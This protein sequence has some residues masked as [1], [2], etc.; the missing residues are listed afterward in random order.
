MNFYN[1][2][3][4]QGKAKSRSLFISTLARRDESG[5]QFV[6]INQEVPVCP[7]L[8][9][10]VFGFSTRTLLN[11][12]FN[13]NLATYSSR[14]WYSKTIESLS[15][16]LFTLSKA[17]QFNSLS[18]L[19]LPPKF[20]SRSL[21]GESLGVSVSELR[22]K[23]NVNIRE[24][25]PD[26]LTRCVACSTLPEMISK[27]KTTPEKKEADR[28]LKLH[29]LAI[30]QQRTIISCLTKQSRDSDSDVSVCMFDAMAN[31]HTKL[32][33]IN[34]R[35]KNIPDADLIPLNLSTVQL[36]ECHGISK[37]SSL[38]STLYVVLDSSRNNKS[39]VFLGALGLTL[40]QLAHLRKIVLLYPSVGHTHLSVDAHFGNVSK[41]MAKENIKDP[42]EFVSFLKT[43]PSVIDVEKLPTIFDFDF[44]TEHM[45]KPVGLCSNNVISI[46]KD[47]K[48]VIYYSSCLTLNASQLVGAETNEV[49]R[50]LFKDSFYESR[51]SP[52]IKK[53]DFSELRMKIRNLLD[54]SRF[55]FSSD[56][57]KNFLEFTSSF[58]KTSFLQLISEINSIPTKLPDLEI[59]ETEDIQ[60]TV[61]AFLEKHKVN[62]GRVPKPPVVSRSQL[63]P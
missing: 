56:N 53:P 15:A 31:K 17:V 13:D 61:L 51:L 35:P 36:A 14:P 57:E 44:L 12:L 59:D 50:K 5:F 24:R 16:A 48:G 23:M 34:K 46:A 60:M 47:S 32:P 18:Q 43:L 20:S 45:H 4:D 58:G 40:R 29:N 63:M 30:S 28:I 25:K 26:S 27:A 10:R 52:T 1:Q 49:C 39:F 8:I 21:N 55:I 19:M 9:G 54:D 3:D 11:A 42:I 38:S 22:T 62:A 7:E 6:P 33:H 37:F 41:S 2:L